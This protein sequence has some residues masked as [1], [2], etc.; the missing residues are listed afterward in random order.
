MTKTILKILLAATLHLL[1]A[2]RREGPAEVKEV[3]SLD[4]GPPHAVLLFQYGHSTVGTRSYVAIL[5]GA[6]PK[7]GDLLLVED[8]C[9]VFTAY[10]TGPWKMTWNG[11]S[12]IDLAIDGPIS[13]DYESMIEQYSCDGITSRWHYEDPPGRAATAS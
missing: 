5:Q 10:R 11:R 12:Q 7:V 2:C 6:P 1:A 8:Y 3:V 9:H 4:S 13:Q